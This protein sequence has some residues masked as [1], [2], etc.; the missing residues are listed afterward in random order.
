MKI[1]VIGDAHF[2]DNLS[3]SDHVSDRR[4]DE[5]KKILDFIVDQA[6]DCQHV[7]F[8]GDNFNSKNN[9]SETNREYT[10][11]IE[12]FKDKDVY[13]IS[14]NHEKKGNGSTAIDFLAKVK[15]PNW[16]IFTLPS[17]MQIGELKVDFVPYMFNSE[18]GV[19]NSIDG[20]KEI[21]EHLDGGDII[22]L[23][24]TI[25]GTTWNG[26]AADASKEIVL[27]KNELEEK[28]NLIV[29]GHIH[30][31]QVDGKVIVAGSLFTS[32]VG[33]TEKFIYKI[34]ESLTFEKIKVPVRPILKLE[35]PTVEEL[36]S[37]TKTSIIKVILTDKSINVE[38]LEKELSKFDAYVIVENYPNER[39]K[40]NIE[41]KN[42]DFSI[43]SLLKLYSEEKQVDYE[44]LKRGMEII[45][46]G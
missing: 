29:G 42:F 17:C 2:K 19:N 33:E 27:P 4:V 18:L 7:V 24:H 20:A 43:N 32:E 8:L 36:V 37:M 38:N 22:F 6:V 35:N 46:N 39:K 15:K 25:S 31:P 44:K 30:E 40:V 21:M 9:S 14:G 5:K 12:R 45:N 16:H 13:I 34:D 28:Y 11:F 23:H 26:I 10:E 3:Y 41:K 1:L